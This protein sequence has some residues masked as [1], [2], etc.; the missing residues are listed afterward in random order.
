MA[1]PFS[2]MKAEL[3]EDPEVR[4]AYDALAPEF[5]QAAT[6]IAARAAKGLSQEDLAER[7]HKP[8]SYVARLESGRAVPSMDTWKRIAAATGTRA[9][10]T[11]EP[12]APHS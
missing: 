3:L 5:E 10:V 2:D 4:A 8:P 11:L 9:R 1:I 7:I 12:T 6:I